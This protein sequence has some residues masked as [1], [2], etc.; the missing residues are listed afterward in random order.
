MSDLGAR[1]VGLARPRRAPI[2]SYAALLLVPWASYVPVDGVLFAARGI[3]IE[4]PVGA[5]AAVG[6]SVVHDAMPVDEPAGRADLSALVQQACK[7][8]LLLECHAVEHQ[9]ITMM[10]QD[11]DAVG[12][13]RAITV[14]MGHNES[15]V[16][17]AGSAGR[18]KSR[19]GTLNSRDRTMQTHAIPCTSSCWRGG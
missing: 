13:R 3:E 6:V 17:D 9:P 10:I 19:V 7:D 2:G 12:T 11:I 5:T 14:H 8:I 4:A 1:S 16:V 15:P 18:R